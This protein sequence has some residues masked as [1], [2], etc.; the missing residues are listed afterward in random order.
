MNKTL[1]HVFELNNTL[2]ILEIPQ[3]AGSVLNIYFCENNRN[4]DK[5]PDVELKY[6]IYMQ[7]YTCN[8]RM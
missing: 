4:D 8:V 5:S 6:S 2:S 1:E 7:S 3:A